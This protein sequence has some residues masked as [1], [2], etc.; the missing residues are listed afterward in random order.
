[1]KSSEFF[2][3]V[4]EKINPYG[5]KLFLGSGSMVN[6]D[7]ERVQGY[8]DSENRIIAVATGSKCT[9]RSVLEVLVHE[10]CHFEQWRKQVKEF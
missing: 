6:C 7:E 1:M 3:Y 2:D 8:F 4:I 5:F 10:Y 9:N